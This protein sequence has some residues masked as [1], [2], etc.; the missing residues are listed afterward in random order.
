[1]VMKKTDQVIQSR[2]LLSQKA[3]LYNSTII[4]AV[5]YVPGNLY[6]AMKRT[7]LLKWCREINGDIRKSVVKW[8]LKRASGS[9]ARLYLPIKLGNSNSR[10]SKRKFNSS[11][12]G[13]EFTWCTTLDLEKQ[14]KK[15][16]AEGCKKSICWHG[17]CAKRVRWLPLLFLIVGQ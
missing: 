13:G 12:L 11:T 2:I 14:E 10:V 1:M 3:D 7:V 15:T 9:D 4:P 8:K 6:S 17:W 5:T 16:K